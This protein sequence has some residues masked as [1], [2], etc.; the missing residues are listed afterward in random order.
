M[1]VTICKLKQSISLLYASKETAKSVLSSEISREADVF[2][3]KS[4]QSKETNY[5]VQNGVKYE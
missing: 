2:N 4:M 1:A 5:W 3:F